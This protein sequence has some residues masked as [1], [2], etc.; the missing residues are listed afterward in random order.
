MH[1]FQLEAAKWI[2]ALDF[3]DSDKDD[4][5][6]DYRTNW[7]EWNTSCTSLFDVYLAIFIQLFLR[8]LHSF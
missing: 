8:F 6:R 5:N 2:W 7:I 3:F 4:K 1:F